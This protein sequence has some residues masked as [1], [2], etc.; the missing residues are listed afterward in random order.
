VR[1]IL[2]L[3]FVLCAITLVTLLMV[4]AP[5]GAWTLAVFEWIGRF[6]L[7]GG[8]LFALIYVVVTVA[9]FPQ[10]PFNLGAGFLYGVFWGSVLVTISSTVAATIAFLLTRYVARDFVARKLGRYGRFESMDQAIEKHGF[11]LVFL[12]RLQPVFVPFAYLNMGLGLTR[13]RLFDY[14]LGTVL[15]TLP[16]TILYAYAGRAVKNVSFLA[17][18]LLPSERSSSGWFFWIGLMAVLAFSI[19]LA[20]IAKQSFA[21][22]LKERSKANGGVPISPNPDQQLL[23]GDMPV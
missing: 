6:G 22:A 19:V 8:I 11:K 4:D 18:H 5:L 10:T 1:K 14:V 21:S 9:L 12:M 17:F 23:P 3:G 16:G 7:R 15:G 2:I 13:V 20:H